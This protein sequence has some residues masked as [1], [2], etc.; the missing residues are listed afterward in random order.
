[1]GDNQNKTNSKQERKNDISKAERVVK[2][3]AKDNVP[4]QT[5]EGEAKTHE[6]AE[7]ENLADEQEI[8]RRREG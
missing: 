4:L 8:E 1:M 6:N 7:V 2:Y 5:E 3:N